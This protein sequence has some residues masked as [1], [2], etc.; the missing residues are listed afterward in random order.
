MPIRFVTKTNHL[1]NENENYK[2]MSSAARSD[3]GGGLWVEGGPKSFRHQIAKFESR[4]RSTTRCEQPQPRPAR[5]PSMATLDT[6]EPET[7]QRARSYTH[8]QSHTGT[9]GCI[10]EAENQARN[11]LLTLAT[12]QST[13]ANCS[14]V[15][16]PLPIFRVIIIIVVAV[17]IVVSF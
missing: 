10:C 12:A 17:F 15:L 7:A 13:W 14:P 3:A 11:W 4:A 2:L 16:P 1:N 5:A 8:T 6:A 9:C